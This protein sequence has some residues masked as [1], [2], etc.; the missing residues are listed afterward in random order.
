MLLLGVSNMVH[1]SAGTVWAGRGGSERQGKIWP[2]LNILPEVL[3][4]S[5]RCCMSGINIRSIMS[6]P[7]DLWR[8][9]GTTTGLLLPPLAETRAA[10][11]L[12]TSAWSLLL[13]NLLGSWPSVLGPCLARQE[14][15]AVDGSHG[16]EECVWS[17][18][19]TKF[20][21]PRSS[22]RSLSASDLLWNVFGWCLVYHF[23][24]CCVPFLVWYLQSRESA[25][26]PWHYCSV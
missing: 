13:R 17:P 7:F 24:C 15:A 8:F 25:Q 16:V 9:L 26:T 1:D 5:F 12:L 4:L 10:T 3:S 21:S 20:W 22:G 6:F 23:M 2:L 18:E 14:C 19:E 11:S